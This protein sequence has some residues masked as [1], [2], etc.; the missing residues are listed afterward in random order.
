MEIRFK[1]ACPFYVLQTV[2]QRTGRL[3]VTTEKHR[4]HFLLR[5][6]EGIVLTTQDGS[7]VKPDFALDSLWETPVDAEWVD[8]PVSTLLSNPRPIEAVLLEVARRSDERVNAA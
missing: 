5:E 4:T 7:V 6:R 1:N 8:R 2:G 3:T